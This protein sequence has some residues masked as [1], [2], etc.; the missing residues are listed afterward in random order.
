MVWGAVIG[1]AACMIVGFTWGGWVTGSSAREATATATHE[2]VVVA[3]APICADRFRSQ[4]DS[5][6]QIAA[7]SKASTWERG[8]VIEKSG[9]ALMPGSKT[10]DS[11]V[12]RACAELLSQPTPKT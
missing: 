5:A 1:A 7:L 12:A 8:T 6:A 3:L 10:A 4:G 11:D 2:A 9:F